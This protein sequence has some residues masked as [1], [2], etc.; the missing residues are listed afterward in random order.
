MHSS[1]I[2]KALR[3]DKVSQAELAARAGLS[4]ETISRW[5]SGVNQ[6]SLESLLRLAHATG[7]ALDIRVVVSEPELVALAEDQLELEPVER[8]KSLLMSGWGACRKAL[9]VVADIGDS[10]VLIGPAAAALAGAPQRPLDGRVDLLVDYR[11]LEQVDERLFALGGWP[12]GVEEIR[13]SG[14]RR[15][16]WRVGRAK[17]TVRTRAKGVEDIG[18]VRSR[19]WHI[20]LDRGGGRLYVASVPDLIEIAEHSGWSEDAIYRTGLRAVL[21]CEHYRSEGSPGLQTAVA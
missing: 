7:A 11:D 17:L 18:A 6:P 13:S 2:V 10:A 3:A 5:E 16:R 20:P 15:G 8:L 14:E 19:A 9:S 12:D 4:R 1:D 21:V